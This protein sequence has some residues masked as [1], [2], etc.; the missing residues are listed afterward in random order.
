MRNEES[1]AR[2]LIS[3]ELAQSRRQLRELQ[4]EQQK[5][6]QALQELT[7]RIQRLQGKVL[8]LEHDEKALMRGYLAMMG[9]AAAAG[10]KQ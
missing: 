5:L 2:L 9:D 6:S 1:G 3:N 8:Q 7:G 10:A 4:E